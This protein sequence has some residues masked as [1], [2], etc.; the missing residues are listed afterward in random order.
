MPF[1]V[2]SSP[3]TQQVFLSKHKNVRVIVDP[4][5]KET[6]TVVPGLKSQ[7][8]SQVQKCELKQELEH[9]L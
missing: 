4:P 7:K 1:V 2:V 8:V 6:V 5:P 9:E 3:V